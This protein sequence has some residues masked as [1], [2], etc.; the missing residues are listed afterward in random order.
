MIYHMISVCK[1]SMWFFI[2]LMFMFQLSTSSKT[3]TVRNMNFSFWP[4][5][6][7]WQFLD[8]ASNLLHSSDLGHCGDNAGSLTHCLTKEHQKIELLN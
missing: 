3:L 5:H 6:S 1:Y 7:I 4:C 2:L 8:Q